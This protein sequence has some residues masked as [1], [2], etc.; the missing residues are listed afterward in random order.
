MVSSTVGVVKS[1]ILLEPLE[2][3]A[4]KYSSIYTVFLK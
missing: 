2:A 1:V 4:L 3:F